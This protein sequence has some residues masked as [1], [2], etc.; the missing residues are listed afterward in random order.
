MRLV[1]IT[2]AGQARLAA[3]FPDLHRRERQLYGCLDAG[4]KRRLLKM[5]AKLL[6]NFPDLSAP[7]P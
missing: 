5:V 7:P 6:G 1:S 4:E 3:M 2:G